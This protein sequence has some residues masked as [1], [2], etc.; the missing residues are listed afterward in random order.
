VLVREP[1]TQRLW[2]GEGRGAQQHCARTSRPNPPPCLP[3]AIQ[4]KGSGGCLHCSFIKHPIL[5]AQAIRAFCN[6]PNWRSEKTTTEPHTMEL[7]VRK[8]EAEDY[9]KGVF[10]S[11]WCLRCQGRM[12]QQSS[13]CSASLA[14]CCCRCSKDHCL[15]CP[16]CTNQT[17][18]QGFLGLLEQLTTV[19]DVSKTKFEGRR[20][21]WPAGLR[22]C[23]SAAH[24]TGVH[25]SKYKSSPLAPQPSQPGTTISH[26]ERFKELTES[27]DYH[28][29]VVEG[30]HA[31]FGALALVMPLLHGRCCEL[32]CTQHALPRMQQPAA[33]QRNTLALPPTKTRHP[34]SWWARRLSLLSASSSTAA[35]RCVLV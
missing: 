24:M 14:Q 30:E 20:S 31:L 4:F 6:T 28:I 35:A 3:A 32:P 2:A 13:G 29:A 17:T 19:G 23:R 16:A 22:G 18:T 1:R 26:T 8:L 12:Q 34:A 15:I 25:S 10:D 7:I 27:P 21:G 33:S 5:Q 11:I 9:D